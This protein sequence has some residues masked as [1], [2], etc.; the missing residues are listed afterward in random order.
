VVA[1]PP[2]AAIGR[3]KETGDRAPTTLTAA[4]ARARQYVGNCSQD[5]SGRPA[6]QVVYEV[7]ASDAGSGRRNRHVGEVGHP[8]DLVQAM[9]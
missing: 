1:P 6:L 7:H 4:A 5:A 8:A 3:F 9:R 2:I